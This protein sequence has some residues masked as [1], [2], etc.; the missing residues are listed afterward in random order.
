MDISLTMLT[1]HPGANDRKCLPLATGTPG[2][3]DS[4]QI[5]S[6]QY[7]PHWLSLL[8]GVRKMLSPFA[9]GLKPKLRSGISLALA[10]H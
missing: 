7:H 6:V 1:A 10:G 9:G 5:R 8:P 4:K 2:V 3:A